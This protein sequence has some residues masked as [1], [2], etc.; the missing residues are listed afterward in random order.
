MAIPHA[1]RLIEKA[2]GGKRLSPA[3]RRHC[4]EYLMAAEPESTNMDL[5]RLFHVTE[6]TIRSDKDI[7]RKRR[8]AQIGQDDPGLVIADIALLCERQIRDIE[9]S[10]KK[11]KLGSTSYLAHCVQCLDSQLKV[12]RAL[13]DLGYYPKNLGNM[14][15]DKYEY[16]AIVT[17]DGSVMSRPVDLVFQDSPTIEAE[18]VP[19]SP[20]AQLLPAEVTVEPDE[21]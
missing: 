18:A 20:P 1:D 7:V 19:V 14:T 5:A 12:V 11:A 4:V 16:R 3:D 10:K 2:R 17:E 15:V 9:V 6:W 13:Q 8:A 21:E